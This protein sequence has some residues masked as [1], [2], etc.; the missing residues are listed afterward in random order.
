MRGTGAAALA[1]AALLAGCTEG[2]PVGRAEDYATGP[3][4]T[5]DPRPVKD[6]A[7]PFYWTTRTT[8]TKPGK[9]PVVEYGEIDAA[10]L[11]ELIKSD[12]PVL[13]ERTVI[14]R[15]GT[16][17]AASAAI[18]AVRDDLVDLESAYAGRTQA[19]VR[20]G[21]LVV[22]RGL[23]RPAQV[24][25]AR[26]AVRSAG[27]VGV[28]VEDP[29]VEDSAYLDLRCLSTTI[30]ETARFAQDMVDFAAATVPYLRPP[31]VDPPLSEAERAARST[32]AQAYR[33]QLE[34]L[35]SDSDIAELAIDYAEAL[36]GQDPRAVARAQGRLADEI[37]EHFPEQLEEPYD[38]EVLALYQASLARPGEDN[39][40][41][42]EMGR[43]MGQLPLARR[44]GNRV[45]VGEAARQHGFVVATRMDRYLDIAGFAPESFVRGFAALLI[46]LEELGC[47]DV[48][49]RLFTFN[50][51]RWD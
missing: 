16:P 5:E 34:A 11:A 26:S 35:Q 39:Q 4:V 21:P 36:Q 7:N 6:P 12:A 31:W 15:F 45:P 42:A 18:D 22:V 38:P 29:A 40:A 20:L 19:V 13:E 28:L 25:E 33:L 17:A 46:R 3:V 43:R 1:V 32:A 30:T 27:A 44:D 10:S 9:P 2:R 14:G 51:V 23:D 47:A 37:G 49:F 8:T 41:M 48:R 24:D 50:E